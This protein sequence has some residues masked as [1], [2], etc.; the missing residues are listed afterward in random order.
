MRFL[1]S[2]ESGVDFEKRILEIYQKCRTNEE[3]QQAF[4]SLQEE[5][6][7]PISDKMK[8]AKKTLFENF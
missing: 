2:I 8:K 3:V 4:N 1:G 5:M 7:E 6:A